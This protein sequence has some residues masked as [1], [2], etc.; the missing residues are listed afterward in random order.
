[1]SLWPYFLQDL[2]WNWLIQIRTEGESVWQFSDI[3]WFLK[4]GFNLRPSGIITAAF[5]IM[6]IQFKS[7]MN[8]L[9]FTHLDKV[10]SYSIET[11][12]QKLLVIWTSPSPSMFVDVKTTV[13]IPSKGD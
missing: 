13:P 12:M 8:G 4:R 7:V 11:F 5:G 9:I 1:M 10:T 6:I 3:F 2:A